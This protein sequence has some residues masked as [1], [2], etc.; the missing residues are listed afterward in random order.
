MAKT[1]ISEFSTTPGNNTDINGINISEGCPP[2]G[3]NNAIRELM[4][5]LKEWQSG[6][7]DVYVIPQG[8][9]ASP[10]L[11]LY[12]D[13]DT[14]LYGD[15]ANQLGVAVGGSSVGYFS[16][17]GWVGNVVAQTIDLV[18]IEVTNI[19]AKDG[20]TSISLADSTGIATFSKAT[21][22]ET[23]DNTNAALRITQLGTGNA[24][25]VEDATNP[26]T[27]PTVIDQFGNVILGTTTRTT[28]IT[29]K[30][31]IHSTS[32]DGAGLTPSL[33]FY[34]WSATA[35]TASALTFRHYPSGTVGTLAANTSGD[36]LGRIVFL[37][38]D[39][40]NAFGAVIR[41]VSGAGGT[42][43]SITYD[44][45][46][47]HNFTSGPIDVENLEVTNIKARDGTAAAS[48]ADSTGAIT[49]TKDLTANGVTL[50]KGLGSVLTNTALGRSALAANTVGD[51][52]TAVGNLSLTSNTGGT[53]NTAVGHVAMTSHQGGSLNTAVG[54][55][56]LTANLNGNNNTAI[57]QSALGTATGSNN[58]AVGS[59]AGS[60]ITNG[61]K[62]TII[63]NYTGN[64]GGLDIRTASN[65]IVLSDGDGN[66]R[67][68]WNGANA[69]FGG[70]LTATTITGT[71]VNSDNL[72]LDGNTLSS[73]D[74]NGNIVVA[75]NGTGITT[76]SNYLKT[77]N[78][79]VGQA[80][81]GTNFIKATDTNG[82]IYLQT[83]G[84]GLIFA[85]AASIIAGNASATT[86]ITTNG[87]SDLVLDT[88][89]GSNSGSITIQDGVN[90]NII[91]APNGTGQVQIT[92][93]ALDLTTIEVTNIKAKDGTAALS[94]ADSTGAVTVATA[95]TANGGA[96]FNE[97]GADVDF[98]VEGDTDANLFFVDASTDRVGIGVNPP[99]AKFHVESAGPIQSLLRTTGSTSYTSL[100]LYNDQGSSTRSLEI[101]YSGS[102]YSGA[103][104]L[105]G[106]SGEQATIAT[107]GAYPLTLG[108]ANTARA[109]ITSG[110]QVNIGGNF[111][112]TNN[113]LQVTGNAAIGYTTAAPTTGLIV[114]GNVGVGTDAPAYKLDVTGS[115][116]ITS[117]LRVGAT[118]ATGG[119]IRL[120]NTGII[121]GR[122]AANSSNRVMLQLDSSDRVL[123]QEGSVV[124]DSS[125]NLGLGVTPSAWTTNFNIKAFDI[126]N[127]C[128]YGATNDVNLVY[129]A[130][131]N[132]TNFIYKTTTFAA[133]YAQLNSGQHQ[134]FNA[135]SGTAGNA[136]SFTQA[137]TLDASG[138]L[139]VG[140]TSGFDALQVNGSISSQGGGYVGFYRNGAT[141]NIATVDGV[142]I[143]QFGVSSG[144]AT[145]R[146][147]ASTWVAG[148]DSLR[149]V[150]QGAERARI[151]SGGYFKASN[152]GSYVSST[153]AYH[154]FV[155]SAGTEWMVYTRHT[156]SANPYGIAINYSAASPNGTS[157]QFLYCNDST[158]LRAEIRS[159]GGLANYQANDV[160]LSDQR[161]K[162]D[163]VAAPSYW[164]KIKNIEIVLFKYKDQTHDDNNVGVIAQ[165]VEQVAPEFVDPDGWGET[166][167]DGVPLKSI[168]TSDMYHAAIKAL[169]E[170]MARIEKLEAEVAALKGV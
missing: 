149:L 23:T 73:T 158:A 11:Q 52:N 39:G 120:P 93:A 47:G 135:P 87:A 8:T 3:I 71:Q 152:N 109:V 76:F 60:L 139:L 112:S 43:P 37:S 124:I 138:R 134:W 108:T 20:T 159:N 17:S 5:D 7:M 96:V 99:A 107:T 1:K 22:I 46:G 116:N 154:E 81:L 151:T 115:A 24:L 155:Q 106:P 69:T 131:F 125:G 91:I 170:A 61:N 67:A 133:R 150:T 123:L 66:P 156:G 6:A 157:S 80:A 127:G 111:T 50:G 117:F 101:D 18:N 35:T 137:M 142:T 114:A 161:T 145:G 118:P 168:Y 77:G 141:N 16:A 88:N 28:P 48:I 55:G 72:S 78:L 41:G 38:Y 25:L 129:N 2:S 143:S 104:L 14:G 153:G 132:G 64:Q 140:Y 49:V 89:D 82:G 26:D 97:N 162:K 146:T 59:A 90:G 62:N 45:S 105:S 94:I 57:G 29:S 147:D 44:A 75:P 33:G 27:T 74:T 167:E 51:L 110:G 34:N 42:T 164:D 130:F 53:G 21:V 70:A 9:I 85:D 121:A 113:T 169:Q 103:V 100:R 165:Q 86:K 54:A 4:S 32:T 83:N 58:T 13:L 126:S 63:G 36:V 128:V 92:N 148:F 19:K 95:L 10:G 84:T 144:V 56:S 65:Y 31:E 160:N 166:P 102:A 79:E 12:G 98:R 30:V 119:D 163:I 122:N 68:Y 136:I 40:T 15:A